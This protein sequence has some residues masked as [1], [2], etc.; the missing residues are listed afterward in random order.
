MCVGGGGGG[1]GVAGTL[2]GV[3]IFISVIN[4]GDDWT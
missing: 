3:S 2:R 4:C 1:G